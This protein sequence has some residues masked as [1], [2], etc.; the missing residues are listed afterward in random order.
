MS[1]KYSY[2]FP[3]D[4]LEEIVKSIQQQKA[5]GLK[6]ILSHLLQSLLNSIMLKEWELFLKSHPENS[7][8][9]FY[10]RNLYLSFGNLNLKVPRVRIGN[11]FCPSILPPPWKR[12]DKDY[13]ELLIAMLANG[14]SKAQSER[15]LKKTRPLLPPMNPNST[16]TAPNLLNQTGSLSSLMPSGLKL[17]TLKL[18]PFAL[19]PYSLLNKK[20]YSQAKVMF[21][22]L[23]SAIST[24]ILR[25]L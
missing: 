4:W 7:S 17:K 21:S 18:N 19:S 3:E 8:N 2:P 24:Y 16:S 5:Q 11:S 1:K 23:R 15:T 12:I 22:R 6:P 10:H 14:Y 25:M 13:E 20:L 9:G